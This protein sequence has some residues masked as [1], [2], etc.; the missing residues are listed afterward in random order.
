MIKA[1]EL[2]SYVSLF[3][4]LAA[5]LTFYVAV[6]P[7]AVIQSPT[8][9]YEE[10]VVQKATAVRTFVQ[11]KTIAQTVPA[12]PA[13]LPLPIVPPRII[14][15]VWP[16]YPVSALEKGIEGMVLVQ[17][18]IGINGNTERLEV[19]TSS[20]YPELDEAAIKAVSNWQ[21]AP[22]TQNGAALASWFEVPIRFRLR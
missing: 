17:A 21:F 16:E 9:V 8:F 4:I 20:G 6:R 15:Q 13:N 12:K 22:A 5:A 10:I 11:P 2:I 7:R 14:S 3:L 18:Y 19:K 1:K